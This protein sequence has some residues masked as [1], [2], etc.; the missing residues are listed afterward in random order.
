MKTG[1]FECYLRPDT[2]LPMMYLDD[3]LDSVV[4]FM[5]VPAADLKQRTY[6]VSATSF[7]PEQLFEEIKKHVPHLQITY[8]ID[9]RQEIGTN[10]EF[11]ES[12]KTKSF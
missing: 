5:K 7:T 12:L 10:S 8:K 6:N 4:D 11:I 2:K 3:C 9:S 1:L